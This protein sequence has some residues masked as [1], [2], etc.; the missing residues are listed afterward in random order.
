MME[1]AIKNAS[2]PAAVLFTLAALL[3]PAAARAG[4]LIVVN[5]TIQAAVDAAS[6]GDTIVVPP[7]VYHESVVVDKSDIT[8]QG[9]QTAVIDATG[10]DRGLT[11]GT[12]SITTDPSGL[13]VCP[14]LALSNFTIEGLTIRNAE[15]DGLFLIG[16]D[17]FHI[18]GGKYLGNEEY[19]I[20]PRCAQNGLIDFNQVDAQHQADDAGIYVGVD[21]HVTVSKN[22][23]TGS[24]IGIEIENTI[25]T[26]VRENRATGNTAA[27]LVVVL[28]GLPRA[29]TDNVLI[30]K[31]VFNNNN[32]PNPVP[33]G[34][35]D[36]VGLLPTGT[37]VL[38][39]GAD[40][41]VVRE[42]VVNGNDSVGLAIIA[43]PFAGLDPRIEPNPDNN[44]VRNN[45]ILK[46]GKSPDPVRA[47]TPGVDIVYDGTGT[48]TC[49]A[50]NV[51]MTDFP[52]GITSFFP[53]P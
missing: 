42:N 9:P 30:E 19:G 21:D 32:F 51:F 22:S 46:N 3:A 10:F 24:P 4:N 48:G 53:C 5:S 40:G 25:N 39:V 45:V 26:V 44:E 41:V 34:S 18:T 12:G 14:P 35:G 16:V 28:P 38:N 2:F 50:N 49:F 23:V 15:G 27:M 13:P 11:V 1:K 6:P 29:A 37:G 36:E 20:F 17:G 33:A 52:P 31:N 8:I 43:N 7:G 47:T